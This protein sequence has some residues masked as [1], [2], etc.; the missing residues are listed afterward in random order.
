MSRFIR[1]RHLAATAIGAVLLIGGG[2][3]I[4][5]T[6][7]ILDISAGAG[8][9]TNPGFRQNSSTSAF[10]RISAYGVHSW[11]SE[12]SSTS[13]HGFVENTS[14]LKHYGSQRIFTVGA[15]TNFTASPT[16]SL[17]GNLNFSG[18]FNGSL[19]NRLISVPSGPPVTDPNNPLPPP[20]VTPDVFGFSGHS[21][22]LNG[23]VGA[24]IRASELS[25]VSLSAGAQHAWFT[26]NSDA[27]Y[28]S[29]Y[30]SVGYSRQISERTSL[31][32]SVYLTHQDFTHG[33]SAN[34]VNPVL[35][36][37]TRLS[38][39]IT[40]SGSVGVLVLSQD[41]GGSKDTTV[42][43]SFSASLCSQ[44]TISSFCANIARDARSAIN[45]R[46][47][48]SSGR[49]SITTTGGVT[50]FRQLSEDATLQASL[51]A[52]HFSGGTGINGQNLRSTYV[53][54][55]TGYDR[56]VGHRLFAGITGGAR[57]LFQ[58]GSDPAV[59]F[60]ANIYLRYR[61]GDVQ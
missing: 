27:N 35:T 12:R 1:R 25:T 52:T 56:K 19:S 2:P 59:D 13:I 41:R 51:Y 61:L 15:D 24:S 33:D 3:A 26:G 37:Q 44:G 43:P 46:V 40:A 17:Y 50:Y 29:F 48:N 38:E 9:S 21:Y 39:T 36:A 42:S 53:S 28:S 45:D 16:L 20:T 4:G 7:N 60:N 5:E 22:R 23:Q 6:S 11:K 49:S 55:V 57:K 58:T 54:A 30:G 8:F 31:G 10:G 18:D 32:P 34:V 47:I 14:Y